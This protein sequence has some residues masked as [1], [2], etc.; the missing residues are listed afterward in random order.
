MCANLFFLDF[1][2]SQGVRGSENCTL[3]IQN[4]VLVGSLFSIAKSVQCRR[5]YLNISVEEEQAASLINWSQLHLKLNSNYFFSVLKCSQNPWEWKLNCEA[6]NNLVSLL[7]H[8][9]LANLLNGLFK[10]LLIDVYSVINLMTSHTVNW[11]FGIFTRGCKTKNKHQ[12]SAQARWGWITV[13]C[14][15][16]HQSNVNTKMLNWAFSFGGVC[17]LDLFS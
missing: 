2:D 5:T 3:E 12:L 14:L 1:S 15:R 16:I 4:T 8:S 6:Q 9:V 11:L 13:T 10:V 7:I 17:G